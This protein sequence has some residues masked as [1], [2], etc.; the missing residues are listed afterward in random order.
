MPEHSKDNKKGRTAVKQCLFQYLLGPLPG[1]VQVTASLNRALHQ[2]LPA[3][4]H[5]QQQ[6]LDQHH[7]LFL[8]EILQMRPRLVQFNDVI[9]VGVH[10]CHKHLQRGR[11][12]HVSRRRWYRDGAKAFHLTPQE[13]LVA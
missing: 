10:L 4:L 6:V 13:T 12:I 7:V 5:A 3:A 11:G 1:I 2:L 9:S 8:A